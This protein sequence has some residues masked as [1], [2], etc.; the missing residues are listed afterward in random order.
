MS[1]KVKNEIINNMKRIVINYL[2]NGLIILNKLNLN[3]ILY[4]NI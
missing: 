4:K 1:E 3:F 2:F